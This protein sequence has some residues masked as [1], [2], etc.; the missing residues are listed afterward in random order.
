M[1]FEF[2]RKNKNDFWDR[3]NTLKWNRIC[4]L[5]KDKIN[6]RQNK[7]KNVPTFIYDIPNYASYMRIQNSL[8]EAYISFIKNVINVT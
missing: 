1:I 8:Y 7:E 2:C 6:Y 4:C 3:M 5:L